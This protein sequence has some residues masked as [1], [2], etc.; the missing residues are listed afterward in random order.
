[1]ETFST[2][3]ITVV[4]FLASWVPSSVPDV[5]GV[6]GDYVGTVITWATKRKS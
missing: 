4:C 2:R 5:E 3:G 1:M 6:T